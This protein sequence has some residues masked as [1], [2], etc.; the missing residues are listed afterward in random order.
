LD[1]DAKGASAHVAQLA[2]H[3]LGK[4]EVIGSSPIVGSTRVIGRPNAGLAY[5]RANTQ[6]SRRMDRGKFREG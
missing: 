6:K 5:L 1:F 2:E 4:G 3:A